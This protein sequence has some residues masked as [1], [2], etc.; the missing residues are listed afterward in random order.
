MTGGAASATYS[1]GRR[2][3][4]PAAVGSL[5]LPPPDAYRPRF[6]H[7]DGSLDWQTELDD[8]FDQIDRPERR[9]AGGVHRRADPVLRRH[10][11]PADRLPRRP[12]PSAATSGACCSWSTRRRPASAAPGSHVRLR[13]RR[14]RARTSSRCP[15]RSAPGLPL[16]AVLTTDAIE[17]RAHER[18]FLFYTTHVSDPLPAAV[19]LA[20]LEVIARER[21]AERALQ[22]GQ[23]AAA[24]PAA[25]CRSATS[26]S[27]TCAAA[28]CCSGSRSWP[29]ATS[30][31]PAPELGAA[32]SRA[33]LRARAVDEH[34]AACP[35]MG[36]VVP[37]RA[38]AHRQR[39]RDRSRARRSSTGPWPTSPR[40]AAEVRRP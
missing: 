21:L 36:G 34:R 14:H 33:L 4:G 12:A 1:A 19:G 20:V 30:R 18:G 27:A 35:A 3:Y 31:K 9:R 32:L 5:A 8:A 22:A 15:R 25:S 39:R 17:A 24:G 7:A 37:H 26:A 40:A 16:A 38:T 6:R 10:H 11:R 2:G 13:A 29:T 23:P 28:A